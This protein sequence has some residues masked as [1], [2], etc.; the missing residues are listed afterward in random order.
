MVLIDTKSMMYLASEYLILISEE[1][2]S[3][4]AKLAVAG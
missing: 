4:S 1:R 2:Y 3:L